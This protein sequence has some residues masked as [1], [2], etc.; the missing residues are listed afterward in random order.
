MRNLLRSISLVFRQSGI[1]FTLAHT[2]QKV[3]MEEAV[4]DGRITK[5]DL[6]ANY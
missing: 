2:H 5:V 1:D 4:K 6:I 3:A